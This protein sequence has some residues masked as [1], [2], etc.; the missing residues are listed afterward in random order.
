MMLQIVFDILAAREKQPRR[1]LQ[2]VSIKKVNLTG[3][4]TVERHKQIAAAAAAVK[5]QVEPLVLL[6]IDQDVRRSSNR[7]T[8]GAVWPFGIIQRRIQKRPAV[9]EP[10]QAIVSIANGL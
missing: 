7:M 4:G 2:V 6:L 5:L 8:P 9:I 3:D 10:L 1:H